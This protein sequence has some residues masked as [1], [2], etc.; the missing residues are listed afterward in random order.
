MDYE[1][2]KGG[3]ISTQGEKAH[4]QPKNLS[5]EVEAKAKMEN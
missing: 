5:S 4:S 1:E 2:G 3:E